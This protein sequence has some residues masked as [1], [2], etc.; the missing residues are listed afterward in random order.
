MKNGEQA[1]WPCENA[2]GLGE[3]GERKRRSPTRSQETLTL[4][5]CAVEHGSDVKHAE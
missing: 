3:C 4:M 2:G 1:I 5:Q